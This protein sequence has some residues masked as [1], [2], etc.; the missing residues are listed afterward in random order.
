MLGDRSFRF[1][2][3]PAYQRARQQL[4]ITLYA[5]LG[6][7]VPT[8]IFTVVS[9]SSSSSSSPSSYRPRRCPLLAGQ[10]APPFA[11]RSI[12]QPGIIIVCPRADKQTAPSGATNSRLAAVEDRQ[13]SCRRSPCGLEKKY[14]GMGFGFFDFRS[15]GT[16]HVN[17]SQFDF[18]MRASAKSIY[19]IMSLFGRWTRENVDCPKAH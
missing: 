7:C 9:L 3:A 4:P 5:R 18:D 2:C 1:Y 13:R 8:A 15:S 14:V 11:D 19:S 17:Q 6:F 10:S 12:V 16:I